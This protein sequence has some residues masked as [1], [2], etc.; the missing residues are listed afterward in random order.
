M[1]WLAMN[2]IRPY[3]RLR[4]VL[5]GER[6]AKSREGAWGSLL[7]ARMYNEAVATVVLVM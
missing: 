7:T 5:S 2:E 3:S 6:F 1:I 4:F